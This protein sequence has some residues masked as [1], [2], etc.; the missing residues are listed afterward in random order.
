[1]HVFRRDIAACRPTH[2]Y[3]VIIY[4]CLSQGLR[5]YGYLGS[6]NLPASPAVGS[7]QRALTRGRL[8]RKSEMHA[9]RQPLGAKKVAVTRRL[10]VVATA[11]ARMP[12]SLEPL[13]CS[14][15]NYKR[16]DLGSMRIMPMRGPTNEYRHVPGQPFT[17]VENLWYRSAYSSLG[18]YD[19]KL[20]PPLA[21]EPPPEDTGPHIQP[22]ARAPPIT[23]FAPLENRP[24]QD[25]IAYKAWEK[26]VRATPVLLSC[27]PSL[28]SSLDRDLPRTHTVSQLYV[29]RWQPP[30]RWATS[31]LPPRPGAFAASLLG[32]HG[33]PASKDEKLETPVFFNGP[34]AHV[35]PHSHTN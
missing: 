9:R 6:R 7:L 5:R 19:P 26:N 15:A 28:L 23:A 2:Y 16:V 20:D 11:L 3:V 1:M 4:W 30:K 22:A 25:P 31:L 33:R 32:P 34:H 17:S 24:L 13:M 21:V 10:S 18:V 27:P 29:P 12:S 8:H 14:W 35:P